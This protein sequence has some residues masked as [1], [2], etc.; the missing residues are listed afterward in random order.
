MGQFATIVKGSVRP[1]PM[2][3]NR[4]AGFARNQRNGASGNS[5]GTENPVGSRLRALQA[6]ITGY[7]QSISPCE[8]Q[9]SA[10]PQRDN[11]PPSAV[12]RQSGR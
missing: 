1:D 10:I 4:V 9:N 6:A 12:K 11:N 8:A 2:A 3:I 7:P 5:N